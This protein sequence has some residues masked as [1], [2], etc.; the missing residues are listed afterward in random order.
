MDFAICDEDVLRFVLK[1]HDTKYRPKRL[2]DA[3]R[4]SNLLLL[5]VNFSDWLARF[6]LWL[7]KDR[8]NLN[9]EAARNLREYVSDLKVGQDKSLVLFLQYF[10]QSTLLVGGQPEDFIHEL[11]RRWLDSN[12]KPGGACGAGRA[13]AAVGYAQGRHLPQ[14]LPQR[15]GSGED[16]LPRADRARDL[17]VV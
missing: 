6:F 11:H 4:E 7:A 8:E 15:F 9:A 13:E 17:G 12:T 1:L 2:F 10:S 16:A 5:G 14:L 3:L